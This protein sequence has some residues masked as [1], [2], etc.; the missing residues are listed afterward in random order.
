MMSSGVRNLEM[1]SMDSFDYRSSFVS[2]NEDER[3]VFKPKS[4][5]SRAHSRMSPSNN[6]AS[7]LNILLDKSI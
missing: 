1:Q 4:R 3:E 7:R 5:H 2:G 6:I